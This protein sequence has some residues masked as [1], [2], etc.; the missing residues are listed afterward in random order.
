[1]RSQVRILSL[2]QKKFMSLLYFAFYAT[3]ILPILYESICIY[4]PKE[5][6]AK[7]AELKGKDPKS[8]PKRDLYYL[9]Y[10][11]GY[12][13]WSFIGLFTSQWFLFILL[14]L[15]GV[16][17]GIIKKYLTRYSSVGLFLT[18]LFL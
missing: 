12:V 6:L 16:I 7:N 9:V 2:L 13:F 15:L 1:M 8:L 3:A 5:V 11:L 18:Q 17:A 10:G 14:L 4:S